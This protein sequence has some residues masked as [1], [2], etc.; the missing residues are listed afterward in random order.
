MSFIACD[1]ST[2]VLQPGEEAFDL[3]AAA[4]PAELP[5]IL[6]LPPAAAVGRD[7][8]DV[9]LRRQPGVQPIRI[10]GLV[11]NQPDGRFAEELRVEG[12]L[13]ERDFAGASTCDSNG[14]RKTTA[15]CDCHDLGPLAF[16][17]GTDAEA[18]FFAPA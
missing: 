17:G 11:A 5:A 8:F 15:V 14:E 6:R 10:V 16:A 12:L 4:V 2:K 1:E 3:P 9:A 18:P 7:Q 13:N